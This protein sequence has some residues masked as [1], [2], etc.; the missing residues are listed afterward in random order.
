MSIPVH[1]A[2]PHSF[3]SLCEFISLMSFVGCLLIPTAQFLKI[4]IKYNVKCTIF[5]IFKYTLGSIEYI[6][7]VG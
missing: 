1:V 4:V 2:L 7:I 3:L 5:T 6:H